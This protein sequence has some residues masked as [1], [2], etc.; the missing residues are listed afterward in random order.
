MKNGRKLLPGDVYQ[1]AR[2]KGTERPYT[3]QYEEFNEIGTYYCAVCG[4]ALI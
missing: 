4:N 3:S 2:Q 1:V